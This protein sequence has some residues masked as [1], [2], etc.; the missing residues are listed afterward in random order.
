MEEYIF[1]LYDALP[2]ARF[3][4]TL[5]SGDPA[6]GFAILNS[7]LVAFGAWC[8]LVPVRSG[9][10]SARGIAWGWV[11]L[12]TVNALAHAALA[13]RAGSYFPGVGTAPVL[14]AV[15]VV[16]GLRLRRTR[17]ASSA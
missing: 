8:Y 6:T 3:A 1:A 16:L 13:L 17:D 7:A 9:W 14:L 11:L 10:A 4:S 12:E 5:V 2:A 15:A